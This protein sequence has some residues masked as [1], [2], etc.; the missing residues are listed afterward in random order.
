MLAHPTNESSERA[1]SPETNS[2]LVRSGAQLFVALSLAHGQ[3][4]QG[5]SIPVSDEVITAQSVSLGFLD[6]PRDLREDVQHSYVILGRSLQKWAA[7]LHGKSV[8]LLKGHFTLFVKVRLNQNE[9]FTEAWTQN[10]RFFF[11][12]LGRAVEKRVKGGGG[13]GNVSAK[14]GRG[15]MRERNGK[16]DMKCSLNADGSR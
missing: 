5:K 4:S 8:P 13:W 10:T 14:R 3:L 15:I 12:S 11:C 6:S 1:A 9:K 16:L 7:E 2:R